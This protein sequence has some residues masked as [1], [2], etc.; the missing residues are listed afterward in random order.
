VLHTTNYEFCNKLSNSFILAL[1]MLSS[2]TFSIAFLHIVSYATIKFHLKIDNVNGQVIDG[3][4]YFLDLSV[5]DKI[6]SIRDAISSNLQI[7]IF[8]DPSDQSVATMAK[9]LLRGR[10][11]KLS[12]DDSVSSRSA[13]VMQHVHF[14]PWEE[15]KTSKV[16]ASLIPHV[17]IVCYLSWVCNLSRR[18]L[19]HS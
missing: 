11:T 4:K 5:S 13:F 7:T 3:L 18:A 1:T 8:T 19:M 15:L 16:T 14:C 17:P 6:F 12:I 10:I 9:N 2:S